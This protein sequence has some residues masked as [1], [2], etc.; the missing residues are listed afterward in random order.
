MLRALRKH[1]IFVVAVVVAALFTAGDAAGWW[2]TITGKDPES[3]WIFVLAIILIG[4]FAL[5]E[6]HK[7][8]DRIEALTSDLRLTAKVGRMSMNLPDSTPDN[9]SRISV[10]VHWEIWVNQDVATDKLALNII[11]VFDRRWWQVWK[12]TH[13]PQRGLTIDDADDATYRKQIKASA[14]RPYKGS[15]RFTY[16]GDRFI[17]G[18]PHWILELVLHTGM[19]ERRLTTPVFLDW[20]ELHSRGS[21]PPL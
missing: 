15:G 5:Y 8:D 18:D 6:L 9:K 21:K 16:E 2:E 3:G 19:P 14:E 10:D 17:K 11:Y 20:D 1:A 7:L 12:K 13:L 4:C